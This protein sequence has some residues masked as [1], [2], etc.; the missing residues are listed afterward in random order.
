MAGGFVNLDS[1]VFSQL[2]R[3]P[4][5]TNIPEL[6]VVSTQQSGDWLSQNDDQQESECSSLHQL[7][8]R[9]HCSTDNGGIHVFV[10]P[11]DG[12]SKHT[13]DSEEEVI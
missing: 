7:K 5:T 3:N 10:H 12:F 8:Q 4:V 2:H 11:E 9:S 6:G 1:L 13:E